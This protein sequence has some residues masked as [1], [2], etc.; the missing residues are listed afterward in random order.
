M[1]ALLREACLERARDRPKG[2]VAHSTKVVR[3]DQG[4]VEITAS[5]FCDVCTKLADSAQ[6]RTLLAAKVARA[7]MQSVA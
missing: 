6:P 4:I 7:S 1:Q 3:P 2:V 5:R